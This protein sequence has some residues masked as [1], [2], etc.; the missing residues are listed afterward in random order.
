MD[1]N[2]ISGLLGLMRKAGAVEI[3]E[4]RSIEAIGKGK[5]RLLLV[6]SDASDKTKRNADF[7]IE[8]HSTVK[9][10]MPMTNDEI[11][12]AVGVGGCKMAA[13][14]D[15]GFAKALLKLLAEGDEKYSEAEKSISLKADKQA[16]RKI[17]KK[18]G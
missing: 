12:S 16:R 1:K 11:A 4:E 13:V 3:G 6:P 18:R 8:G 5:A 9:L 17:T 15:I 14:T 2:R 10:D 7:Y